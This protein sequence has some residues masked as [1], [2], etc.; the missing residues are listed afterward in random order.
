MQTKVPGPNGAGT[1]W[2]CPERDVAH[3]TP[4]IMARAMNYVAGDLDQKVGAEAVDTFFRAME[5]FIRMSSESDRDDYDPEHSVQDVYAASGLGDQPEEIMQSFSYWYTQIMFDV[6]FRGVRE[7]L[8]P[9]EK[10][11]GLSFLK[12]APERKPPTER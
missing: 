11:M 1:V 9:G 6:Y 12:G 5:K 8:H 4:P 3:C 10:P 2:V 7:A